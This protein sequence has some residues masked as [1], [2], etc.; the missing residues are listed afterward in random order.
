MFD[1]VVSEWLLYVEKLF[2]F[3]LLINEF[4]LLYGVGFEFIELVMG[5]LVYY[6]G[7]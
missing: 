6:V 4:V 7:F 5:V 2:M 1:L 3:D